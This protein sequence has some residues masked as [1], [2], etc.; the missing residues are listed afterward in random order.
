[1]GPPKKSK[2]ILYDEVMRKNDYFEYRWNYDTESYYLFNPYTGETI[3]QASFENLNRSRSFWTDPDPVVSKEAHSVALFR[4]TYASRLWGRRRFEGWLSR[5]AAATQIAAVIRGFLVRQ[6]LRY[7][8]RHRYTKKKCLE[9]GYY[10]FIDNYSR[11]EHGESFWHKPILAFPDDIQIFKKYDPEDYK[12]PNDKYSFQPVT[13][14]GPFLKRAGLGKGN[15]MRAKHTSFIPD[16]PWRDIAISHP[17]EIDLDNTPLNSIISWLDGCKSTSIVL[18]EYAQMKA[19]I[20]D[21]NWARV[22]HYMKEQPDNILCQIFG[23]HCFAKSDIPL[24]VSG[25]LDFVRHI[26]QYL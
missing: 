23:F 11:E 24:D 16:N 26:T 4:E 22:L 14:E 25:I 2:A 9:T 18:S 13:F 15:K 8:F 21:N 7:Y 5:D 17:R 10:Y 19:A 12:G 1:M 3:I 20:V 6:N